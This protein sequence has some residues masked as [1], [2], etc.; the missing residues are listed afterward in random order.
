MITDKLEK[1]EEEKCLSG[2]GVST[3]RKQSAIGWSISRNALM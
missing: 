1:E 2:S 3:V